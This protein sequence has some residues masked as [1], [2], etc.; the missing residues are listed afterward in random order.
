MPL[1]AL[2]C[3]L[4][5]TFCSGVTVDDDLDPLVESFEA[6]TSVR[7]RLELVSEIAALGS[8]EARDFLAG[9][10]IQTEPE[11]L[12][13]AVFDALRNQ[14]A[15]LPEDLL[16][17][18]VRDDEPYLRAHALELIASADPA[19]TRGRI[20]DV[21]TGDRDVRVRLVA[22]EILGRTADAKT[23]RFVFK[24]CAILSP[25]EQRQAIE[26]LA[27]L[28]AEVFEPVLG[29][30]KPWWAEPDIKVSLRLLGALILAYRADEPS[31]KALGRLVRDRDPRVAFAAALGLDRVTTG[32]AGVVTKKAMKKAR[33]VDDRCA[34]LN[35]VRESGL[36]APDLLELLVADLTHRDWTVQAAAAEALGE[37][38]VA[39]SVE[40]LLGLWI[41]TDRWQVQ[42][43]CIQALGHSRQASAVEALIGL[44]DQLSG[45][46]AQ[47]ARLSLSTLTGVDLGLRTASWNRWWSDHGD[48]FE[49][50]PPA[51]DAWDDLVVPQETF[52]FYGIP[53]H[54][55]RLAFVLDVSGSMQGGKLARLKKEL[56]GIIERLPAHSMFNMVFF[57]GSA[58][59]WR[60]KL[61]PLTEK[62]RE[63]AMKEVRER[64]AGGGTNLWDGFMEAFEDEEVDTI[65]LLSD[66]EPTAGAVTGLPSICSQITELNQHRRVV[67]H[68][69]L[70]GMRSEHLR[71][72][73]LDSGGTYV[74]H[75]R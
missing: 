22:I 56:L 14:L 8:P 11:I 41:E 32:S 39:E 59:P 16:E 4:L 35:V 7:K 69:V 31:K 72:L 6:E 47:E 45:R 54:S 44:L 51:M 64:V 19:A 65:Y 12:K 50:A 61:Q 20:R 10:C 55:D 73:A 26:S 9:I 21:L 30:A 49:V 33:A 60:G 53:V 62:N 27:A 42:L 15:P 13:R 3:S 63:E 70:I 57:S 38:R 1:I 25:R 43:A 5:L 24:V 40:P 48:G 58:Y 46:L 52:V 17:E 34:V 18:A 67:I 37:T 68:V 23:A 71:E 36:V 2:F 74:V 66:G 29:G 75:Q 28:P